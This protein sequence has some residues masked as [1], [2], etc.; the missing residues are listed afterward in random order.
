MAVRSRLQGK[1]TQFHIELVYGLLF[2]AGFAVLAFRVDP[3][4]AAFE[5]GLVVGYLLRIWE[6]MAIYERILEEMVSREA[7]TQVASEVDDQVA[8]E[9]EEQ[10][11]DEVAAEVDDRIGEE[12][13]TQVEEEIGDLDKQIDERVAKHTEER[14]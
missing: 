12:V 4:I 5:G 8:A 7:E 14:R 3:R 2:I 1:Q 6:K 10:V 13:Q 9:V 11:G